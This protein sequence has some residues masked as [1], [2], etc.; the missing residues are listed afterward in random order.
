MK[1]LHLNTFTR[2]GAATAAKR[3]HDGLRIVGIDSAFGCSPEVGSGWAVSSRRPA[4]RSRSH[5]IFAR[6]LASH[7]YKRRLG[8][9]KS[10]TFVSN[11]RTRVRPGH[12]LDFFPADIINL[13]WIANFID[14]GSCLPWLA[15]QAPLVWTLHDMSPFSG[16][17]HYMPN[18]SERTPGMLRWD[19]EIRRLKESV[20]KSIPHDRL[21]VV[22]PSM[23][24]AREARASE[25]LGRF[26]V[27]VIPNGLDTESFQPLDRAMAR[28]ALG[29]QDK[30]QV[31]GFIAD[32]A[33]DPR[34]GLGILIEALDK[35]PVASRP[36]LVIAGGGCEGL[37]GYEVTDLGKI[38]SERVLRLFYSCLDIF[39]CPSLQDNLPNTVLESISCGTPV[40]AFN[41]GG[42]PD[43]VR[44]GKTGWLAEEVSGA[45]MSGHLCEALG[46]PCNL[47]RLRDSCRAVAVA[48][49]SL[50]LQARSYQALYSEL[51]ANDAS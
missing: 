3:L 27:K 39:A 42:L 26:Q 46:D 45:S 16:V 43:M 38:E 2:G 22:S 25:L 11:P 44:P 51:L 24:L 19:Q 6:K 17:W 5:D 33:N 20:L 49:Y 41:V 40:I 1:I 28:A 34:K 37:S 10:V 35:L 36:H 8:D 15:K 31:V 23:W 48:K 12:L 30:S 18:E 29:L 4:P 50:T 9:V 13:H 47:E 7:S 14:W 21:T 32:G